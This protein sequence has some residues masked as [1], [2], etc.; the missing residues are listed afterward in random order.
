[1]NRDSVLNIA[2]KCGLNIITLIQD[3]KILIKTP[4]VNEPYHV[5]LPLNFFTSEYDMLF[6]PTYE[7]FYYSTET[8]EFMVFEDGSY[9]LEWY[10]EA[11]EYDMY[12]NCDSD[13]HYSLDWLGLKFDRYSMHTDFALKLVNFIV[14]C[15]KF[16]ARKKK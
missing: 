11:H 16:E 1:M 14:E 6:H 13:G 4:F 3:D 9:S 12:I 7:S 5:E 2:V 8:F 10:G 15:H